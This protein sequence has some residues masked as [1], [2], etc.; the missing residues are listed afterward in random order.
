MFKSTPIFLIVFAALLS[1]CS[2]TPKAMTMPPSM[3]S[4]EPVVLRPIKERSDY[5]GTIKSRKSV[6]LSP[7]VEGHVTEIRVTA[8][9]L[10]HQGE[11]I[12]KIDSLMQ[13]AQTQAVEAA[14]DSV[15]SDLA[16]S[17][18]TLRSLQSTLQSK[19]AQ[20]EYAKSQHSRYVNLRAA[21]A[22]SQSDLDSWNNTWL[23]AQADRDATLE[24]IE[25]QKMTIQKIDRSHNQAISQWQA[26]KE[27]LKYY[28]IVAPFTGIVGDIPVKVGDHVTSSTAL[29]M[30]TENHPLEVY[31]SIPAEKAVLMKD[32]MNVELTSTEGTQ[33][34]DSKVI[35]VAPTVDPNSQTVLVK[36]LYPNS[37]NLLRADQ[38][39][40]AQ[41]LWRTSN[42]L[43]VPTKATMQVGGKYF[44]FVAQEQN[45]K[46]VAHQVEIEVGDIEG[47]SYQVKRGLKSHD[48]VVTTGI[49]RLADG[50]PIADKNTMEKSETTAQSSQTTH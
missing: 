37:K 24:Q 47:D 33:F 16:T 19:L 38:A 30:L 29:T 39:V 40:R 9:Q 43:T 25:A 34:G 12:M 5:L 10:V 14:A 45:G 2:E 44:V 20:V 18:A 7:N 21:G 27:Q 35:F 49:Q 46:L 26:Q 22:V 1:A 3:V 13:T 50:A 28:N 11:A 15:Q 17:K 36:T 6:T 4:I 23:S 32:G 48:R 42:G 8:G 31:I 41:F